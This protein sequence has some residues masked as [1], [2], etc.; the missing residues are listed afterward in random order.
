MW[1]PICDIVILHDDKKEEKIKDWE[2]PS[3]MK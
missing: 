2:I 3:F 1:H